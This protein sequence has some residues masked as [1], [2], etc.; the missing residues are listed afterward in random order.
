VTQSALEA[1]LALHMR[2]EKLNPKTEYKFSIN[3]RWRA[4]FAFPCSMILI[5]CEGGIYTNGRHTRGSGF[6]KDCEKYSTAAAMGWLVLRFTHD[7]IK[8]GM[9]IRLIKEALA[10]RDAES[11][12]QTLRV[13]K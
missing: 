7:Q 11:V 5:E 2:V 4:D 3:R 10:F 9:A 12:T 13:S 6:E 8:N 1:T